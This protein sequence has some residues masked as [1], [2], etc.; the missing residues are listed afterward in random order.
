MENRGESKNIYDGVR[1]SQE[2]LLDVQHTFQLDRKH[3]RKRKHG[4]GKLL[5]SVWDMTLSCLQDLK[6]SY[7]ISV[8]IGQIWTGDLGWTS[9]LENVH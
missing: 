2:W 3:R 5:S 4:A 9:Q 1:K 6:W 7:S 8:C